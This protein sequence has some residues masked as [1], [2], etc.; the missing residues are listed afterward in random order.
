MATEGKE[1]FLKKAWGFLKLPVQIVI[2]VTIVTLLDHFVTKP[3]I[4]HLES[5]V[6]NKK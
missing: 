6:G 3:G 5:L 1:G 4:H 2:G